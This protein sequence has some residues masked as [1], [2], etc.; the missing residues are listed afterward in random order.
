VPPLRERKAE[1]MSLAREFAARRLD[2]TTDAVE[3]MLLWR[4]PRN[5]RELR[6]MIQSFDVAEAERT[7]FDLEYLRARHPELAE[8]LVSRQRSHTAAGTLP[9]EATAATLPARPSSRE[10][11]VVHDDREKLERALT[12]H[13]GNVAKVA[14]S[15]GRHR[16]HIYRLMSDFGLDAKDFRKR[17][18]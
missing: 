17:L 5:V 13:R 9:P 10:A 2:V 3:A 16:A 18:D 4:Y 7:R 11:D 8:P 15:F 1:I 14:E 12:A 6:A